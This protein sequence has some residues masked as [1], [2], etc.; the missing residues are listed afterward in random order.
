MANNSETLALAMGRGGAR[1]EAGTTARTGNFC[2]IQFI[3]AGAFTALTIANSD[4]T[5]TGVTFPAGFVIYGDITAFT[6]SS[7]SVIAYKG[8]IP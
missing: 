6:L 3:T 5:W 1:I 8:D 7:G 2:A 4:G